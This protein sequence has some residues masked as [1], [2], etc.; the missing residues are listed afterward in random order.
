MEPDMIDRYLY[1][2]GRSLARSRSLEDVLAEA[3]D[4][5]RESVRHLTSQGVDPATAQRLTLDRFG[6]LTVVTRAYATNAGGLAMATPFTRGAGTIA[7]LAA[8]LWLLTGVIGAVW[9]L[10]DRDDVTWLYPAV[11]VLA[12]LAILAT[13][14]VIAGVLI[15]SGGVRDAT[16]VVALCLMGLSTL[17]MA[18]APWAWVFTAVPLTGAAVIAVRRLASVGLARPWSDVSLM[19]S[20]PA[21]V[22][23]VLVGEALRVGP[24][25]S[26]GD[27]PWAFFAGFTVAVVAF[28]TGLLGV[29]ARL[30]GEQPVAVTDSGHTTGMTLAS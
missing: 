30:H 13:T 24:Q 3:E 19:I 7:Y 25:D 26:Y 21:G 12:V 20:W 8:A 5:L 18:V 14:T 6:D 11:T 16:A 2:L 22:V 29:G 9:T 27:Y 17:M 15:R 23:I 4:H 1:E 10:T 28:A